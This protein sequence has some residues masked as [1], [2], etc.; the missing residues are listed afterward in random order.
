MELVCDFALVFRANASILNT[1]FACEDG[2]T[3]LGNKCVLQPEGLATHA[4]AVSA[5]QALGGKLAEPKSDLENR[6]LVAFPENL[7]NDG[8]WLGLTD[9]AEEGMYV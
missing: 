6:L 2:W 1:G 4:E 8:L 7:E 9:A 3:P 5:C